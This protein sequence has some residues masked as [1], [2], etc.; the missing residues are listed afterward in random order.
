MMD[1][2]IWAILRMIFA[3]GIVCMVLYILIKLLK[4]SGVARKALPFNNSGIK[5]LTSQM[6]APQKYISLVD[7]GGEILALGVSEAQ[8]TFLTKIE[9]KAFLEKMND[10]H[11]S[12]PEPFSF[13]QLFNSSSFRNKGLKMDLLGRFRGR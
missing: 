4:R 2:M 10:L 5:L 6:I 1:S 8:I 13:S 7:I 12:K 3:L 9:N 11:S